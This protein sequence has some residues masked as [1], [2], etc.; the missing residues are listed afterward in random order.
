MTSDAESMYDVSDTIAL[1]SARQ[2]EILLSAAHSVM[3]FTAGSG[4]RS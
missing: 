4:T 1:D 3:V 2:K